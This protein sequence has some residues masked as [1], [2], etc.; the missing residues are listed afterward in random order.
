[1]PEITTNIKSWFI[2]LIEE[3]MDDTLATARN[4][5]LWAMGS[6]TTEEATQ[7]ENY[8]DEH[9]LYY[10]FLA[11]IKEKVEGMEAIESL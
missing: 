2:S 7:H 5:H 11:K 4:E 9:R 1:M 8:A 6:D 10:Q 3:E